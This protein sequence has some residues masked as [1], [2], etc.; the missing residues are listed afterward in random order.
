LILFPCEV[1]WAQ[2]SKP[3]FLVCADHDLD[4]LKV[5]ADGSKWWYAYNVN[6]Q[7]IIKSDG[8]QTPSTKEYRE[9]IM[10]NLRKT[11]PRLYDYMTDKEKT[12]NA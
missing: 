1:D 6:T 7:Y 4:S 12:T 2:P 10:R 8:Q 9:R 5:A 3:L 11:N